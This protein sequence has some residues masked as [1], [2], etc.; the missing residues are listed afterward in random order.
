MIFRNELRS[1]NWYRIDLNGSNV[2]LSRFCV[3]IWISFCHNSRDVKF[4]IGQISPVIFYDSD[5]TDR[6]QLT[7]NDSSESFNRDYFR[8][9]GHS[10]FDDLLPERN[11][12]F[13]MNLLSSVAWPTCVQ[14][15]GTAG[16]KITGSKKPK[17]K[18][19]SKEAKE[20]RNRI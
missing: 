2:N 6:L 15:S 4:L 18:E 1:N 10:S 5:C 19:R 7:E 8:G 16:S 17:V 3:Y 20:S 12:A 11:R 9:S 14:Y 13:R